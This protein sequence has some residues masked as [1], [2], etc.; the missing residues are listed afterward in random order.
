MDRFDCCRM[1]VLRWEKR[2]AGGKAVPSFDHAQA[3]SLQPRPRTR[4]RICSLSASSL[5]D[6]DL[7]LPYSVVAMAAVVQHA[8]EPHFSK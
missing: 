7:S 8:A 5:A 6:A 4:I 3:R 2:S 1:I